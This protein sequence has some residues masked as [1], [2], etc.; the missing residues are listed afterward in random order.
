MKAFLK[1][2]IALVAAIALPA[3]LAVVFAISAL[4]VRVSVEDPSNDF[5]IVTDYYENGSRFQ[6]DVNNER[7]N[8]N[9]RAA[10]K[11]ASYS[12]KPRLWR[13][14]A[15]EMTV[16]EISLNTPA[17]DGSKTIDIPG[18]TDIKVIN[19]SPGP[20]GY[21]FVDSYRS[22]GN[23]MTEVFSMDGPRGDRS[24]IA[25][26]GRLVHFK[27]PDGNNFNYYNTRFLGWVAE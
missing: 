17:G 27:I 12:S 2:N 23:I 4:A 14:N 22:G 1:D 11:D 7:L 21:S 9:Y 3:L 8:I 20:D 19:V 25:K 5:F 13:V 18:V 16:Q 15:P 26:N 6:F 10:E 24:G